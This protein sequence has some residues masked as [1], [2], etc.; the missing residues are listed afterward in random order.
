MDEPPLLVHVAIK[1]NRRYPLRN[2]SGRGAH[3]ADAALSETHF[4]TAFLRGADQSSPAVQSTASN[5]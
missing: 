5:F 1:E 4:V 3:L 2:Y